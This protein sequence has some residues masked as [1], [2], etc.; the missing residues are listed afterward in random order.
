MPTS[1]QPSSTTVQQNVPRTSQ[2]MPTTHP[3][4][5]S[6]SISMMTGISTTKPMMEGNSTTEPM[7]KGNSTSKSMTNPASDQKPTAKRTCKP[8]DPKCNGAKLNQYN[9]LVLFLIALI[10]TFWQI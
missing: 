7:M 3:E 1:T 4:T 2:S 6:T 5:N 8:E 10:Q 9:F